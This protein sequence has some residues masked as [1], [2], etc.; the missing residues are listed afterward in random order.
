MSF[1]WYINRL[2][3]MGA[4][5]VFHRIQEKVKKKSAKNRMEGWDK[6][7]FNG[8]LV[9]INGVYQ[10]VMNSSKRDKEAVVNFAD[11]LLKD[12]YEVLGQTWPP[13]F[14]GS[15]FIDKMWVI[16][17][18]TGG[19]WDGSDK[20]TFDIPYRNRSNLGDVKYIWEL[21]RLQFL[22][23]FATAYVFTNEEHYLLAIE[24]TITSWFENNPPFRGICWNS[25]IELALRSISLIIVY[26]VCQNHLNKDTILKIKSLLYAHA[27]WIDRYPS[28]FSSAN[29]HLIAEGAAQ[30]LIA[31]SMPSLNISSKLHVNGRNIISTEVTKQI[32]SDGSPAEQS[33]TYG[34]FSAEFI[35]LCVKVARD[36]NVEDFPKH[37]Q[38]RL[39]KYAEF[40]ERLMLSDG[41]I[42]SIGD[43]D[44]G[45]V[46]A[47]IGNDPRYCYSV[48][49]AITS[50]YKKPFQFIETNDGKLLDVFFPPL[51]SKEKE[52]EKE[53]VVTFPQGGITSIDMFHVGRNM[54]V[55]VDHGPLG[56]LSIAAHGHADALALLLT[57][58][59]KPIFIDPGTYLYHSGGEWRD[60]F[61]GTKSH[62]T[63]NINGVNQSTITG[64]FNWSHKAKAA[65]GDVKFDGENF[66]LIAS[67][68]G[69]LNR[70]GVLHERRVESVNKGILI[71]D[72][73]SD[74]CEEVVELVFQCPENISA[75]QDGREIILS[76]KNVDMV[77][78]I[79][80]AG[81]EIILNK[82]EEG[83]DG[84]WAS[85]SFGKKHAALRISWKGLMNKKG[86]QTLVEFMP[87]LIN[88]DGF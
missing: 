28:K 82:G 55:I 49:R 84:G 39:L 52:V 47:G 2:R 63:L 58:D 71:T 7:S 50:F 15:C 67:H 72:M 30:Y 5:E 76:I 87:S 17:P 1:V 88:N 51:S 4:K 86:L 42:A 11:S 73:F 6:Y 23:Y 32:F 53:V 29:N 65:L 31:H 85:N 62:N 45:H 54:S 13:I 57:I 35:L 20:Y 74:D 10:A 27:V 19:F 40:V 60:W 59:D 43:D 18:V 77:L 14:E 36:K 12:K 68:D 3:S 78:M 48:A 33:P 61:R 8:E 16:D 21:N 64:A 75:L 44:E 9:A 70:F 25:G 83:V 37:V 81:G 38:A 22:Q 66:S 80:P 41:S 56:Y 24:S 46:I 34:G 69:Y 79:F 26:S